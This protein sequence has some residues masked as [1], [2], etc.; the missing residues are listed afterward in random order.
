MLNN[1]V[2]I[3]LYYNLFMYIYL[4]YLFFIKNQHTI[5]EPDRVRHDFV[6]PTKEKCYRWTTLKTCPRYK[7]L[8]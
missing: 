3:C 4:N 6:E 7:H 1:S 2:I 8:C 5:P